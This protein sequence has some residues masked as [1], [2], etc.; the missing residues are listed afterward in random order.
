MLD[1]EANTLFDQGLAEE[2]QERLERALAV[3][4]PGT[5]HATSDQERVDERRS[6]RDVLYVLGL[7]PI[8][9]G[10]GALERRWRSEALWDLARVLRAR[11]LLAEADKADG[12]RVAL[13]KDR[14]PSELVDVALQ[15]LERALVIG[16]GKTPI[17]DRARTVRELE[18]AQA[19]ANLR[20]AVSRGFNDLRKLRSHP[21]STFL[22]SREDLRLPIM[23]MAFPMRPIVDK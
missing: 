2:A 1:Q 13:W 19:A 9:G 8:A 14:P 5:D 12:E 4:R 3:L 6:R 16:Y 10:A 21:D 15:Q 23:D 7:P 22:L 20:L 11:K 18:L 17:S